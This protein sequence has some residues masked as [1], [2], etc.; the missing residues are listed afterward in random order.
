VQDYGSGLTTEEQER[1]WER[2][3]QVEGAERS[4]NQGAGLGLGLY[5]SRSIIGWHQGTVGVQST[6]GEGAA[7]W[8]TLPLAWLSTSSPEERIDIIPGAI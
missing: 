6:P 8:F 1:V 2:F 7:F 5:I 4:S 3:Y